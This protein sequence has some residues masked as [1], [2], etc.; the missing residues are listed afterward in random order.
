MAV[1]VLLAVNVRGCLKLRQHFEPKWILPRHSV[2]RR[3][4]DIDGKVR[5]EM[6]KGL[7]IIIQ[8]KSKHA[9]TTVILL[10]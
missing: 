9:L 6:Y 7:Y 2:I 1:G 3:Y 8:P 10:Q 4:L 5:T